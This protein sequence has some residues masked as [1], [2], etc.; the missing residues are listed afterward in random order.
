MRE[1]LAIALALTEQERAELAEEILST[2]ETDEAPEALSAEWRD[3]I[4]GRLA[5]LKSGERGVAMSGDEL[6][7]HVRAT[8]HDE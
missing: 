6:I 7:A 4:R 8:P 2:L 3:E 5:A 1:A